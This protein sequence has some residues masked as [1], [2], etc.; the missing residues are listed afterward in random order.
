MRFRPVFTLVGVAVLL[1]LTATAAT[2][3]ARHIVAEG[4][5]DRTLK[6]TGPVDLQVTTGAGSISVHAGQAGTVQ[7][8]GTIR[9]STGWRLDHQEAQEKVRRL[10]ANPPIGQDGNA[11]RIGHIDDEE[12]RRNI[13]I[14]Y[15][16]VV[17]AETRL[18]SETGSGSQ[19]IDGVH[20]PAEVSAGSGSLRISNIGAPVNASTG[21]G[22]IE[23]DGVQGGVN[24][25]T[26][27]GH[28]RGRRIAGGF[29]GHT[30][31]GGVQVEQT[32]TGNDEIETGSG[33]VEVRGV[34]GSLRVRTGSG[35]I[36]AAGEP[37][38]EWRLHTGSGNVTVRLPGQ[39]AF[40]LHA[41]TSSGRI[42][43]NHPVTV[44]GTISPREIRGKVRGGGHLVDVSTSSGSV[45]ID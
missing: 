31:S 23:L 37:I 26:G 9:A 15:E 44:E 10:E 14:S 25:S 35:G 33:G 28:I 40:D 38:G 32:G 5:F 1:A 39:V 30:G 11:I 19:T 17:P 20:G 7:V 42:R 27:S 18:R 22:S 2:G 45:E 6:V 24:T 4:S 41:H 36:T 21:S 16:I 34:R 29:V 3:G 43:T 13:S 12:L 8:H